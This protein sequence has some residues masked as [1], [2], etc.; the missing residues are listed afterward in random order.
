MA[1]KFRMGKYKAIINGRVM[2]F[3][4]IPPKK[5]VFGRRVV[6]A[7]RVPG[8]TKVKTRRERFFDSLT[9][10]LTKRPNPD[11]MGSVWMGPF[12]AD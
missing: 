9:K 1:R 4:G 11:T 5:M 8:A 3:E 6:H 2:Y 7:R 12:R 10:A